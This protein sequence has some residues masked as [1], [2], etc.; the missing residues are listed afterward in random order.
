[1]QELLLSTTIRVENLTVNVTYILIGHL[2]IF[3]LYNPAAICWLVLKPL[4]MNLDMI[5]FIK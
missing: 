5:C 1:M 2:V 4:L 3:P